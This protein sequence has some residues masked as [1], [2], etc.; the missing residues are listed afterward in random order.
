MPG[1]IYET[2][3]VSR[4]VSDLIVEM[5]NRVMDGLGGILSMG[6]GPRQPS[7]TQYEA[8]PME[9]DGGGV[10]PISPRSPLGV[11]PV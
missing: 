9:M 2:G 10:S 3:G 6:R 5:K 4:G 7:A 11:S 8:I 1:E